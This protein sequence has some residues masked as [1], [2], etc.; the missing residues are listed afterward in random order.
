MQVGPSDASVLIEGETGT[1]KELVAHAIHHHS[2]R[3]DKP[4]VVVDCASISETLMESELFG[5]VKGAYTGASTSDTGLFRSAEGGTV[6]LDE[7]GQIP[8]RSR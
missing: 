7:I 5:H 4:F 2:R 8:L 1:G 3:R 6:F